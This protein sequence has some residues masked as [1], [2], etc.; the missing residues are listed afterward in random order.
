MSYQEKKSLLHLMS[1]ILIPGVYFWIILSGNP[2]EGLT[3]DEL[4]Y[5]WARSILILIPITIVIH[6]IGAI[7]FGIGNAIITREKP[8]AADERDKL[9]ELKSMRNARY[10]FGAGCVFGLIALTMGMSVNVWF[11]LFIVFSALS[12]AIES[13]SQLYFYR[14]G[15]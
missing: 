10:M 4:L 13:I 3:T 15:I 9:I 2:L 14:N 11:A 7:V 5:F 12:Q 8:P 1:G 6:I